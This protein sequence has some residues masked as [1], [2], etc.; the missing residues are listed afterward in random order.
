MRSTM[1]VVVVRFYHS[2]CPQGR[3]A[4]SKFESS[5]HSLWLDLSQPDGNPE[6]AVRAGPM[7]NL[8]V[9]Q[10]GEITLE[11]E[12]RYREIGTALFKGRNL[13]TLKTGVPESVE[14]TVE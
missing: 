1:S 11:S 13:Q 7:E 4:S 10:G 12:W 2:A 9:W 3:T 8:P 14:Y 5:T 6:G